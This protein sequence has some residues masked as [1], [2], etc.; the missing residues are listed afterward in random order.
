[1]YTMGEKTLQENVA[2]YKTND[3]H[4]TSH[5]ANSVRTAETTVPINTIHVKYNTINI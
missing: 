4:R 5:S 2:I 3:R 1:M